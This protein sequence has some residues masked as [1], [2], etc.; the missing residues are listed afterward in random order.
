MISSPSGVKYTQLSY[1]VYANDPQAEYPF[2][3]FDS[4]IEIPNGNNPNQNAWLTIHLYVKFQYLDRNNRL[5]DPWG[6]DVIIRD[7]K[8]YRAKDSDGDSYPI[9]DWDD[10]S[11][12]EFE[13]AF[14][15]GEKHWNH[16]FVLITPKDY[17]M[18]D[19]ESNDL[20]WVVR[21]N[22]LC[23]F[24]LH[25]NRPRVNTVIQVVR[26]DRDESFSTGRWL[27][28]VRSAS[29]FRSHS[30][31]YTDAD[32]KDATV[33]HELG[34]V[35]GQSHI[36]G[37]VADM[38]EG[39]LGDPTCSIGKKTG[40]ENK[41]YVDSKGDG[42]NTMGGG[43]GLMVFNAISWQKRIPVHCK[44]TRWL[45]WRVTMDTNTPTRKIPMGVALVG[46]PTEF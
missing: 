33:G 43:K 11:K 10:K 21:P 9:L 12:A 36:L 23:L 24:R 17:D 41:C 15:E 37:L 20:N 45:D 34:H 6:K 13:L 27:P 16:K 4:E 14:L 7:G 5:K 3:R 29:Q 25:V 31:L 22:V 38:S 44:G 35:L 18:L 19:Y 8:E 2:N 32:V 40:N 46:K 42:S 1:Q 39:L 28:W 30:S 26:L